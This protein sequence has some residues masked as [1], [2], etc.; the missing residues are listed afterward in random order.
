MEKSTHY[1]YFELFDKKFNKENLI[2][3]RLPLLATFS[4]S[5]VRP[6]EIILVVK[7]ISRSIP[8]ISLIFAHMSIINVVSL[9][10][11]NYTKI[12]DYFFFALQK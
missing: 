10:I 7:L 11:N 8:F 6:L 3:I 2:N 5:Q 12:A 4:I 1:Y 9:V